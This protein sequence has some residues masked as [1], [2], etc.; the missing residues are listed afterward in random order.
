MRKN[1]WLITVIIVI[2][3][4]VIFGFGGA[5]QNIFNGHANF[6][7]YMLVISIL[8]L[9]STFGGAYLGAKVSGEYT[10][11][12]N[13]KQFEEQRFIIREKAQNMKYDI[14]VGIVDRINRDIRP[15]DIGNETELM[16]GNSSTTIQFTF[17]E[18]T[19]QK[20]DEYI[21]RD[22][23]QSILDVKQFRLSDS[24]YYLNKEERD[25]INNFLTTLT[26]VITSMKTL[27]SLVDQ[28]Y[29]ENNPRFVFEKKKY[30]NNIQ[31]M[32]EY[33]NKIIKASQ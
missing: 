29:D 28:R 7:G 1:S 19:F 23:E 20:I 32:Y 33:R 11:K 31:A 18:T 8:S 14:L 16:Y 15:W 17:E 6:D 4:L 24:F 27:N 10:L 30:F 3:I 13:E 2:L 12:A 9:F 26:K 5:F 22:I 25:D 21:L